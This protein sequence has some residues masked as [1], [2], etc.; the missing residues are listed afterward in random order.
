MENQVIRKAQEMPSL[1]EYANK[2]RNAGYFN[3]VTITVENKLFPANRMVLSCCSRYFE[4]MFKIEMKEHY[5]NT[6]PIHNV[7]EKTMELLIEFMYTGSI[8]ISDETVMPLLAAADYLQLDEVKTF[9]FE[10]LQS[11]IC[12][13]T[14]FPILSAANLYRNEAL[15]YHIHSYIGDNLDNISQTSDFK[16]LSKDGL[17]ACFSA[18]ALSEKHTKNLSMYQA[19]IS[20]T[21]HDVDARKSE[22]VS[23]FQLI[24]LEQ[25]PR[26]FLLGSVATEE[27]ILTN[28]ACSQ[29]AMTTLARLIKGV[30]S[31]GSLD[32]FVSLGGFHHGTKALEIYNTKKEPPSEFPDL[33]FSINRHVSLTLNKSIYCI[34]G[35]SKDNFITDKVRKLNLRDVALKWTESAPMNSKRRSMG[36]AVYKDSLLVV[37]GFDGNSALAS[38]ECYTPQWDEWKMISSLKQQRSGCAVIACDDY[39]YTLGGCCDGKYL[40]S[41]ERLCDLD[42]TWSKIQP[43]QTP[44]WRLAVVNCNGVVYAIGGKSGNHFSTT[45]KTVEKY[46]ASFNQWV[47]VSGMRNHRCVHSASVSNGLIY[48]FGGSNDENKVVKEIECYNPKTDEWTVVGHTAE[49]LIQNSLVV[50]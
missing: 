2:N 21:K 14:W 20:W 24:N 3:D 22:F 44:R 49:K 19:I 9:C 13:D 35:G 6:I 31:D 42:E 8:K 40:S 27:L 47:Y 10:F 50:L 36:A 5:E 16:S 43:M 11:V 29:I 18:I 7:E 46:D 17:S 30:E 25:L 48:V 4:S 1:L 23:L 32:R 37:G 38:V 12:P 26:E 28:P 41:V 15:S 34:G 39:L 33:P 45:L